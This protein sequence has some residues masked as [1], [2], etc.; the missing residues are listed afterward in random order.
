MYAPPTDTQ[1]DPCKYTHILNLCI[2]VFH[3]IGYFVGMLTHT[4]Q[5]YM[6]RCALYIQFYVH[7]YYKAL[8]RYSTYE[9]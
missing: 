2:V 1:T 6:V 8:G 4:D 5:L 9:D 3:P 7:G